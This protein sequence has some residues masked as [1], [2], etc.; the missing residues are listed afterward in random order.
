[1]TLVVLVRKYEYSALSFSLYRLR[2]VCILQIRELMRP[3][4]GEVEKEK[5]GSEKRNIFNEGNAYAWKNVLREALS[6]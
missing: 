1:M 2:L 4:R 3:Q 6:V 5:G